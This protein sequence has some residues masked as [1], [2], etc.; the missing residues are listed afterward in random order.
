M[1]WH[2]DSIK[3]TMKLSRCFKSISKE[4]LMHNEDDGDFSQVVC[5]SREIGNVKKSGL[6]AT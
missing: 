6:S 3:S 4:M 1:Q 2:V 5:P